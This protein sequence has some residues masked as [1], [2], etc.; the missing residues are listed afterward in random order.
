MRPTFTVLQG[1]AELPAAGC[2]RTRRSNCRWDTI[3]FILAVEYILYN[4]TVFLDN[5]Y[6]T[7]CGRSSLSPVQS[8]A[9]QAVYLLILLYSVQWSFYWRLVAERSRALLVKGC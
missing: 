1:R 2:D 9:S 5:G 3:S 7:P 6:Q 4:C 8:V